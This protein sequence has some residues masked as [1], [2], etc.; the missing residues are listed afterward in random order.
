MV[1]DYLRRYRF[2]KFT[3]AYEAVNAKLIMNLVRPNIN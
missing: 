1:N 3:V 2:T